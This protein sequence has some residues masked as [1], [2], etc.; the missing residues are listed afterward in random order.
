MS[1]REVARKGDLALIVGTRRCNG[2]VPLRNGEIV[3]VLSDP[4]LDDDC[5]GNLR[6]Y[7]EVS[8][9]VRPCREFANDLIA[10]RCLIPI[11]NPDA[12][13]SRTAER[14]KPMEVT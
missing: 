3:Q 7:N 6:F 4:F 14:E 12:D 8:T 11:R 9:P 2:P 1:G 13:Q 10:T 5:A